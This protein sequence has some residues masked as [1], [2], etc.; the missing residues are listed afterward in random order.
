[1][2][3]LEQLLRPIAIARLHRL[4]LPRQSAAAV[5]RDHGRKRTVAFG[6]EELRVHGQT[7]GRDIDLTRGG[8][9]P[10]P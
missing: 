6:L 8:S 5:Q 1:M 9:R 3:G 2:A 7:V 4:G 10:P